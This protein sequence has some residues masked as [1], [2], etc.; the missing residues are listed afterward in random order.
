[1]DAEP[2]YRRVFTYRRSDVLAPA[3]LVSAALVWIDPIWRGVPSPQGGFPTFG[4]IL[5]TL[6]CFALLRRTTVWACPSR[7][8]IRLRHR[9]LLGGFE[10]EFPASS[11]ELEVL[12]GA[13]PFNH[14]VWLDLPGPRL[15]ITLFMGFR[16][17]AWRV[18][19]K[20]SA[21]L[22]CAIRPTRGS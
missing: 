21:D 17:D 13:L 15:G 19:E 6:I 8:S 1:M 2:L 11:L 4:A 3:L 20:L 7:R 9:S 10:D 18:A 12:V 22:G 16:R 5:C 14:T